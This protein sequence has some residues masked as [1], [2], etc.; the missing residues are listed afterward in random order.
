MGHGKKNYYRLT[1]ALCGVF[2]VSILFLPSR[3]VAARPAESV[4]LIKD[5]KTN[6]VTSINGLS[7]KNLTLQN[8]PSSTD[9]AEVASQAMKEYGSFFGL[10]NPTQEL[11]LL[12]INSDSLNMKHVRY[13]QSLNSIPVF[14]G[15]TIVHL[16]KDSNVASINGHTVPSVSVLT[17]PLISREMAT[18][19]SKNRWN[20]QGLP[21]APTVVDA[22]LVIFNKGLI[23]NKTSQANRL[24]WK[25]TLYKQRPQTKESFFIDAYDGGWL[26]QITGIQSVISRR[27][28]DCGFDGFDCYLDLSFGGHVYGR[29]EGQAV[30]GANPLV[31]GTD[32]DDL[33]TYAGNIHTYY[34]TTFGINGANNQGGIGDGAHNAVTRTDGYTY[35]DYAGGACPNAYWDGFSVNFC[36]D[37]EVLDVVGH[38]YNH[39]VD[40]FAIPPEGLT[41][42]YESGALNE[43]YADI[44]GEAVQNYVEGSSDWQM[45]ED[46]PG[47]ALRS[48]S[49]PAGG[50]YPDRFYSPYTYCGSSDNG[51]VHTNNTI[52]GHAAYLIAVG[53]TFNGCTI[54]GIGRTKEEAI[55]YR[56]L[57]TYTTASS[58]FN[59]AYTAIINA[60]ND[61]YGSGSS[62]CTQV[63]KALQSVEMDQPGL[64][65]ATAR[66]EPAC[67]VPVIFSTYSNKADGYYRAGSVID[68]VITF[69]APVTSTGSVTVSLNS[70]GSCSFTVT[71]SRT[72]TC[73][74]TVAA[75]ESA[76]DLTTSTIT[77]T[78]AN[79]YGNALVN[80]TPTYDLGQYKNIT[81]DTTLPSG[82]VSINHDNSY[83]TSGTV[84]L[85][86]I[87]SDDNGIS[88]MNIM[89]EA[90]AWTGW[91]TYTPTLNWTIDTSSNG[92]KRVYVQYSDTAGNI[93]AATASDDIIYD[94]VAAQTA[95]SPSGGRI[96]K[97]RSVTLTANES[98]IIYYTT[99]GS[100][101]TTGSTVYT[102]PITINA[103]TTI[104]YFSVDSAG[105]AEVY[106]TTE[107]I[108]IHSSY[109]LATAGPGSNPLVK[110]FSYSGTVRSTPRNLYPFSQSYLGGVHIAACDVDN[111]NID[112]IVVGVG[113]GEEPWVKVYRQNG[114]LIKQFLAYAKTTKGGVYVAC[115]DLNGDHLAEIV[116]GVPEGFGPHVRVFNGQTGQAKLTNGFFAYEKQVRT[117]IR[118]ATGDLDG[119][120]SDEIIV[121]TGRGAGAHVRTFSGT[122]AL[123][124]TPGFFVYEK[125]DRSGVNV[126]AGDVNADGLDEIITGSGV[127]RSGEIKIYSR[128]GVLLKTISPYGTS[129]KLGVKVAAGDLD[130]DGTSEI[131]TATEKGGAPQIRGFRFSGQVLGTFFAYDSKLRNG[132]DVAVGAFD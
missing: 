114:T 103:D 109:I 50:G 20:Q 98:S 59:D 111:D 116:T 91:T 97:G 95:A 22:S 5:S 55:L 27:I 125:T 52:L 24:A 101:P 30:R 128:A 13:N 18:T 54:S 68:I 45:G 37:Y 115:G 34:S 113:S 131:V 56:A 9:P 14:G 99:D 29:S 25:V 38:E 76:G 61:L 19:L 10:Q 110:A 66:V 64:C 120:G 28:Y 44:F 124:F 81:V 8:K 48:L 63:T 108:I 57:T 121:G 92:T 90:G 36:Q 88:F 94:S 89:N 58:N 117:G 80:Y 33:Y 23:E 104:K 35:I 79:Q 49:D 12:T 130:A 132:V 107:Y 43:A 32:V 123:K 70:G 47:G 15:Q 112:E 118:V 51:G 86:L 6:A 84:V 83:T 129:Y 3:S 74:Y 40:T 82:S 41:Y 4:R 7:G 62:D 127:G 67:T 85:T 60:C 17:T 96:V 77:G 72:G 39:A 102:G 71:N 78:L 2:V 75:G 126:A 16:T 21:M 65:S 11:Q 26:Y 87:A 93:L 106:K 105:N 42:A 73:N 119:D 100:A 1:L 122:G 46:L 53:G 31:G 69:S